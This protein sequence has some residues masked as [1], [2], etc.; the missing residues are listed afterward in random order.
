MNGL[1]QRAITGIIFVLVVTGCIYGGQVS[2]VALFAIITGGSLW[3]FFGLVLTKQHRRDMIRRMLALGLGLVPFF[4]STIVQLELVPNREAF[5]AISSLL[6]FP[7]TFSVFIYELYT[8]SER[9]FE[10]VAFVMLG[11][12][13]IGVPFALLLFV[14][15]DGGLYYPNLVFALLVMNWVNDSGAYFVGSKFGKTPL[16]PRI[17]P[18]K[19]WEGSAGGMIFTLV[20]GMILYYT[21]QELNLRD[22][23][24]LAAI[25]VIFGS[26]G[27]LVES[28]LKRSVQIKDSGGL[29]P[30]HGGL[31]DRFDAFIFLLPFATAY[32]LWIR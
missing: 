9:P 2:F 19:T 8:K 26:L 12:V 31:L 22:W 18:K 28:M 3:E 27:D 30:G 25:V 11:M 17:S 13:Y 16:F 32:L 7:F 21:F 24:V 15:F 5:I 1:I 6:F 29:L 20:F 4:M 10:N 14:A 23:L